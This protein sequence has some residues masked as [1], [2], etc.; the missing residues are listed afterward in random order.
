[1][2][3]NIAF[4]TSGKPVYNAINGGIESMFTSAGKYSEAKFT[5]SAGQ[6]RVWA[7]TS[8]PILSPILI[9]ATTSKNQNSGHPYLLNLS[10]AVLKESGKIFAGTIPLEITITD[11]LRVK[12]FH[13]YRATKNGTCTIS[14]KLAANDAIGK[15]TIRIKELLGE[16]RIKQSINLEATR[17]MTALGMQF[18]KAVYFNGDDERIYRFFKNHQSVTIIIGSSI[19]ARTAADHLIKYMKPYGIEFVIKDATQINNPRSLTKEE[20]AT[21]VGLDYAGSGQIKPGAKNSLGHSGFD[22]KGPVIVI[23]NPEDNPV[24]NYMVD[25]LYLPF[26]P[27]KNKFPGTGRGYLSWQRGAVGRMQDS[28]CLVAHDMDGM[29]EAAGSLFEIMAGMK[30]PS[31]NKV[32]VR[33]NIK[34]A[35]EATIPRKPPLMWKKVLADF[36]VKMQSL[37]GVVQ[38]ETKDGRAYSIDY[39]GNIFRMDAI[40]GKHGFLKE[41][42]TQSRYDDRLLKFCYNLGNAELYIYWGGYLEIIKENKVIYAKQLYQDITAVTLLSKYMI[43]ALADGNIHSYKLKK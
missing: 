25:K 16:T 24:I 11:S 36:A 13:L 9:K 39:K 42:S 14:L 29:M 41:I 40:E 5:F 35:I 33:S 8:E 32:P 20:A 28:L 34:A 31:K 15:W 3:T 26:I 10:I 1:M 43:V 12:R 7:V 17:K 19:F 2:T 18:R 4:E 38:V 30:F 37:D 27:V 6:M 23:G 21:W 22:V